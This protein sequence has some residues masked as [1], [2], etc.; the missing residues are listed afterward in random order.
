[1][2]LSVGTA[3]SA[4]ATVP[5]AGAVGQGWRTGIGVWAVTAALA[6][7]P[8][9][10]ARVPDAELTQR[11]AEPR[12]ARIDSPRARPSM[13]RS[14]TAWAM[15]VFFGTQ[16]LGAYVVMGWMPELFRDAGVSATQAGLLL[17]LT[18][19]LG[20]PVSLALPALAARLPDQRLVAAGLTFVTGGGYLGL[21]L[22]PA[23]TPWLWATL[24][25]I[26]NGAFPL[27]VTMI[28]LRTRTAAYTA[29]LSGFTQ[30][31]GY[32]LAAAGPLAFGA[33]HDATGGWT[34]P[35][36]LTAVLLVPQCLAGLVAGRNRKVEDE[37]SEPRGEVA[38]E[39][40]IPPLAGVGA[41]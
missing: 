28:G 20:I 23:T 35:I 11:R 29:S 13:F 19:A 40:A 37:L 8:W 22:A 15:A 9:L 4:A 41:R 26:G 14:P 6:V 24:I 18:A 12:G 7:G 30:S 16:S 32:L 31:V 39:P 17:G 3:L 10:V 27:A 34:V 2:V 21:A 1:M 38:P 33:L 5:L 36:A 25:G